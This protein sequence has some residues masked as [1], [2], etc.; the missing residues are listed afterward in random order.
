MILEKKT[1]L[2]QKNLCI[3]CDAQNV[4]VKSLLSHVLRITYDTQIIF[5]QTALKTFENKHH[6]HLL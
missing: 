1:H 5:A 4:T 2:R 6:T 3:I